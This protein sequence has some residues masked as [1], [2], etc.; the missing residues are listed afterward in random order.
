ME[1]A[2]VSSA[3]RATCS[4]RASEEECMNIVIRMLKLGDVLKSLG[5]TEQ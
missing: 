5:V 2:C 1:P 4:S 3:R